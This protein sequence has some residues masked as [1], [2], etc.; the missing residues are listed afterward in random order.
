MQHPQNT[1]GR[2]RSAQDVYAQA[3]ARADSCFPSFSLSRSHS[4]SLQSCTLRTGGCPR[5]VTLMPLLA[6]VSA[7]APPMS[8]SV[9]PGGHEV[10]VCSP[11]FD[12]S[13][14]AS[15]P[16]LR[17]WALL[18]T[19]HRHLAQTICARSRR[20]SSLYESVGER[21]AAIPR[22]EPAE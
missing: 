18:R 15:G 6:R 12:V 4:F 3:T 7:V 14:R 9:S 22:G 17:Y 2:R 21:A 8:L 19:F 10:P 1:L 16:P 11:P 13:V 5:E 20:Q